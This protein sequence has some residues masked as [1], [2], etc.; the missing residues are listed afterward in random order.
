MGPHSTISSRVRAS[1]GSFWTLISL[2][3]M[4]KEFGEAVVSC[5]TKRPLKLG[6]KLTLY[7]STPRFLDATHHRLPVLYSFLKS[8]CFCDFF[9]KINYFFKINIYC[10]FF[11]LKIIFLKIKNIILTYF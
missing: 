7:F 8:F 10:V 3:K 9:K 11:M 4:E 6:T 2:F 1:M 5:L